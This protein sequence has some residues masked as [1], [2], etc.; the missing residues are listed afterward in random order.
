MA[1]DRR[2]L[3]GSSTSTHPINPA[4]SRRIDPTTVFRHV[5]IRGLNRVLTTLPAA[6]RKAIKSVLGDPAQSLLPSTET[7]WSGWPQLLEESGLGFLL[8]A[9]ARDVPSDSDYLTLANYAVGS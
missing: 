5:R 1:R 2:S 6:Q 3:S 4:T 8:T 9:G 7:I